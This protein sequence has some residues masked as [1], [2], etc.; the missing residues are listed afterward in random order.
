MKMYV[1]EEQ[2]SWPN[3]KR[4]IHTGRSLRRRRKGRRNDGKK[5]RNGVD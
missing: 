4:K 5:N 1:Y 3:A 2:E